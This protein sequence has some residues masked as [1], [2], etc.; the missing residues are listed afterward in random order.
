MFGGSV[1]LQ[2]AAKIGLSHFIHA[3]GGSDSPGSE[4]ASYVKGTLIHVLRG[5]DFM[6][7]CETFQHIHALCGRAGRPGVG[8]RLG[9][10][11]LSR[12]LSVGSG[13]RRTVLPQ[14]SDNMHFNHHAFLRERPLTML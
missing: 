6:S 9:G 2:L 1:P 10:K 3:F 12:M 7:R 8:A 4:I 5:S 11:L 14:R 13:Q